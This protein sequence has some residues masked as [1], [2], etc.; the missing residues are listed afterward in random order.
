LADP[1]ESIST[2]ASIT[3]RRWEFPFQEVEYA[4]DLLL[5]FQRFFTSLDWVERRLDMGHIYDRCPTLRVKECESVAPDQTVCIRLLAKALAVFP[6]TRF[7]LFV[8]MLQHDRL[9]PVN[10]HVR[11]ATTNPVAAI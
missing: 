3:E 5:P 6:G 1:G 4:I 9:C 11:F 8:E 7:M 2:N 10:R